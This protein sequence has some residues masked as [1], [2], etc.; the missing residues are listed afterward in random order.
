MRLH[1]PGI[2]DTDGICSRPFL[3]LATEEPFTPRQVQYL[4]DTYETSPRDLSLYAHEEL[5]VSQGRLD[6]LQDVFQAP[7]SGSTSH[8][9]AV[10]EPSPNSRSVVGGGSPHDEDPL[11]LSHQAPSFQHA[12]LL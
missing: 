1:P 5:I 2:C 6:I 3:H 11:G 4:H 10:I 8:L 7:E 9:I 12:I